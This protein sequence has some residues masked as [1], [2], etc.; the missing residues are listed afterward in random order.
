VPENE[1]TNSLSHTEIWGH[2]ELPDDAEG[3][4]YAGMIEAL[5]HF[6]E[7]VAQA[8]PDK[9][10]IDTLASE[11]TAWASH[12]TPH[13]VTEEEQ[14]FAKQLHIAG[15]GQTMAPHLIV[16]E[17]DANS[18]RGRVT[19]GRYYL[20]GNGA[21][22]GGAIPLVFDEILG[23][24]SS[25][26]GRSRARTAYLHVDYRSITPVEKELTVHAWFEREEGRKRFMRATLYD[27]DR[28]CAECNGLFVEL[29]PGQP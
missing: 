18:A 3:A 26:A 16:D 5:R 22:H 17:S 19:F 28:L 9:E 21:V 11:L 14:M 15:R 24:L 27:G 12:L 10:T 1:D 20:G 25:C 13:A 8:A 4:Q 6:L 29:L 7:R 23:R 2:H